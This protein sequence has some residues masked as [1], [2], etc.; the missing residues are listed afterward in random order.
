MCI[1]YLFWLWRVYFL[2]RRNEDPRSEV[3]LVYTISFS[4]I[5]TRLPSDNLQC[6]RLPILLNALSLGNQSPGKIVFRPFWKLFVRKVSFS[7]WVFPTI[8]II[9][10]HVGNLSC[11]PNISTAFQLN[12]CSPT[13][14]FGISPSSWYSRTKAPGASSFLRTF[15]LVPWR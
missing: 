9:F 10:C 4:L 3:F 11:N 14:Y 5:P 15:I 12:N 1:N 2:S 7:C 8:V 6:I 13:K